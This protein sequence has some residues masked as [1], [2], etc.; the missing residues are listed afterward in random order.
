MTMTTATYLRDAWPKMPDGR[1]Y[2]G[3]NLL[4]LVIDNKSPFDGLWDVKKLFKE[5]E[6]NFRAR[7]VDVPSVT[8]G[9][10]NCV[11]YVSLLTR[12]IPL[13]PPNPYLPMTYPGHPHKTPQP[14]RHPRPPKQNRHQHAQL[15]RRITRCPRQCSE[16]RIR[17]V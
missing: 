9:S 8:R 15:Q 11:C 17:R 4:R 13:K 16:V 1:D 3:T 5:V 7:I 14:T 2:D 12:S 10:S 6:Q